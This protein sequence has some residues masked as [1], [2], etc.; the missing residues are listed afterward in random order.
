MTIETTPAIADDRDRIA[1]RAEE[2]D[3]PEVAERRQWRF[4]SA[5]HAARVLNGQP[6]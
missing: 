3:P 1:P 6:A 4:A 5:V 2:I